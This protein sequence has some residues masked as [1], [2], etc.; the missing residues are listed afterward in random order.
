[1]TAT[2]CLIQTDYISRGCWLKTSS[3]SCP[4]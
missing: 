4:L 3:V 1:V 2:E